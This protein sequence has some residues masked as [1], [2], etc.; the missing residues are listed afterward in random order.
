MTAEKKKGKY[1]YYRCTGFH[2]KCG[3]AYI[4]EEQLATLLATVI[5]PIQITPEIANDIATALRSNEAKGQHQRQN[6]IRQLERHRHDVTRKLDRGYEDFTGGKISEEFWS[7]KSQEWEAELQ[8][9]QTEQ[10]KI[11][12]PQPNVMTTAQKI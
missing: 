12:L 5:A 10:A 7:R 4:R 8:N 2:G 6:A 9:V 1:V 11:E 3:N